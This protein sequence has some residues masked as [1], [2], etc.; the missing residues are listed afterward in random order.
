MYMYIGLGIGSDVGLRIRPCVGLGIGLDV[1]SGILLGKGKGM[2][3]IRYVRSV[4]GSGASCW[5]P[6]KPVPFGEIE[7][8]GVA[9]EWHAHEV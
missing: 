7:S 8:P 3:K 4:V 1:G 5:H 2:W 9:I 6:V